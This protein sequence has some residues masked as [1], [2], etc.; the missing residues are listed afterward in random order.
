M[1]PQEPDSVI[2][3]LLGNDLDQN[4]HEDVG[5]ILR[6]YSAEQLDRLQQALSQNKIAVGGLQ[7]DFSGLV[8][9]EIDLDSLLQ[10][11]KSWERL[12]AV[13]LNNF[14]A[15]PD[16]AGRFVRVLGANPSLQVLVLNDGILWAKDMAAFLSISK[17]IEDISIDAV[18]F[19]ARDS[20]IA[21]AELAIA[22]GACSSLQILN[23]DLFDEVYFSPLIDRLQS[24]PHQLKE[25]TLA[26]VPGQAVTASEIDLISA[27]L[28]D[29]VAAELMLELKG[30]YFRGDSF[31]P[32]AKALSGGSSV[33]TDFCE[34]SLDAESTKLFESMLVAPPSKLERLRLSC[35]EMQFSDTIED[36]LAALLCPSSSLKRLEVDDVGGSD[37]AMT[38]IM[39]ALETNGSLE[40]LYL[41]TVH[42]SAT[43]QALLCGIPKAIGL[44]CLE[45]NGFE[46]DEFD[47]DDLR[48][49]LKQSSSIL[50]FQCDGFE[51]GDSEDDK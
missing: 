45:C 26:A 13:L 42:D 32:I 14:A 43:Y 25:L 9:D 24:Q 21:A 28:R 22:V 48:R 1:D 3:Y 39:K 18:K 49:S 36:V 41:D 46:L 6:L 17:S 29:S 50:E 40:Y 27:L 51:G 30:F 12:S 5:V 35:T 15:A 8:K 38:A 10:V 33:Q 20:V 11:L 34:C 2:N 4:H 37:G 23:I 31:R 19:E 16:A 47:K 44:R 7:F